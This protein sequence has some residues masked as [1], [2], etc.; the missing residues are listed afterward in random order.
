MEEY[1]YRDLPETL[2]K[3]EALRVII[4]HHGHPTS[5]VALFFAEIGDKEHYDVHEVFSWLGY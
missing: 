5:E 3:K 1:G 2:T 4:K